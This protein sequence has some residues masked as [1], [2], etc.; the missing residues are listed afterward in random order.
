MQPLSSVKERADGI[1]VIIGDSV[2]R[3][4]FIKGGVQSVVI[5]VNKGKCT[6]KVGG[7]TPDNELLDYYDSELSVGDKISI[8]LKNLKQISEPICKR[9]FKGCDYKND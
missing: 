1:E 2:I 5:T 8:S 9:P 3:T 4:P 6:M 7:M